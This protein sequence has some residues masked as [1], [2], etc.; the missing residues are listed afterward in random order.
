LASGLA[1]LVILGG[2]RTLSPWAMGVPF[3]IGQL[4][5]AAVLQFGARTANEE[6]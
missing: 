6:T 4:L 2:S 1:C 5:V 3:G